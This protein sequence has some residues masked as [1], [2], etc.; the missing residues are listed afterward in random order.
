MEFTQYHFWKQNRHDQ[1]LL[2]GLLFY[3]S[4]PKQEKEGI[5]SVYKQ[6]TD[7]THGLKQLRTSLL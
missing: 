7:L 5:Y 3:H 4:L 1:E 6:S 2:H